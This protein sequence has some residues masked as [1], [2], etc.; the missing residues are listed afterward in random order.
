MFVV[1]SDCSSGCTGKVA[2]SSIQLCTEARLKLREIL[3]KSDPENDPAMI[4]WPIVK[5]GMSYDLEGNRQ[6]A[7][8]HYHQVLDMENG[9]GAQFMAER[10]LANPIEAKDPKIG[11]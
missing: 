7:V 4:A 2:R 6:E 1:I 3:D 9:S 11:Y 8:K 10:R 5:I